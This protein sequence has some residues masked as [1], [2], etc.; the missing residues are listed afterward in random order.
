MMMLPIFVVV[1]FNNILV[2]T[3]QF[4]KK[5]PCNNTRNTTQQHCKEERPAF[6]FLCMILL[7]RVSS[8]SPIIS[9]FAATLLFHGRRCWSSICDRRTCCCFCNVSTFP[10]LLCTSGT[11]ADY[12]LTATMMICSARRQRK[13][14]MMINASA[15]PARCDCRWRQLNTARERYQ[16]SALNTS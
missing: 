1:S 6:L 15:F 5:I 10:L 12:P 8:S 3:T 4:S 7:L 14:K 13:R 11:V 9:D 16:P 2:S